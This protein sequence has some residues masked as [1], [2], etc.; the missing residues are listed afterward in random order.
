MKPEDWQPGTV[1]AIA[2]S[3]DDGSHLIIKAVNYTENTQLLLTRLQGS[4]VSAKGTVKTYTVQA[5][6]MESASLSDPNKIRPVEDILQYDKD[7]TIELMPYSVKV[8]N[9]EL[10]P[11][12]N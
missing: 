2:T 7:M 1:D 12:S 4:N 10:L 11:D 5:G 9:I 3:S 8:I 6:L